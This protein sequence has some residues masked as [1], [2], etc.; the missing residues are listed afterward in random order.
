MLITSFGEAGTCETRD[1]DDNSSSS[2]TS[3]PVAFAAV[4]SVS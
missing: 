1:F 4:R 2:L 3:A